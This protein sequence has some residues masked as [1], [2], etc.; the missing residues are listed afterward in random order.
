M[1]NKKG[2][3]KNLAEQPD[4]QEPENTWGGARDGAGA[5]LKF[6]EQEMIDA[7][8]R[9]GGYVSSAAKLLKCSVQTVYT[10]IEKFESVRSAKFD[11]EERTLDSAEIALISN[12]QKGET[13]SI[14][15]YLK[16]KGKN[17]GY[18]ER[19]EHALP[20][21]TSGEIAIFRLPD[22]GRK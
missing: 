10:Y 5:P 18:V 16:T 20:S 21:G 1:D 15:F 6:T 19:Q 13:A 22:N 9:A 14:I 17:R 11:I 12:I 2:K 3:T 4:S 7:L 8:T